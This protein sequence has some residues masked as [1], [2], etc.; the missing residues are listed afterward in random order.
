ML[1]FDIILRIHWLAQP[2]ACFLGL[3]GVKHWHSGFQIKE[4]EFSFQHGFS[5]Y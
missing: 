5:N 4:P 2:H 1:D 3:L